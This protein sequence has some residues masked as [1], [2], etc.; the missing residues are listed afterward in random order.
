MPLHLDL[1]A[2]DV[3]RKSGNPRTTPLATGPCAAEKTVV[4]R[5]PAVS[6]LRLLLKYIEDDSKDIL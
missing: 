1:A 6:V 3:C 2:K 4:L 5:C